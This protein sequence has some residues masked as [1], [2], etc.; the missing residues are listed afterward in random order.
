MATSKLLH[1]VLVLLQVILLVLFPILSPP[2]VHWKCDESPLALCLLITNALM[3]ASFVIGYV[4]FA[5]LVDKRLSLFGYL[6]AGLAH[7]LVVMTCVKECAAWL[8]D[9][10]HNGFRR[11]FVV[12]V[13]FVST[14]AYC[15]SV[16]SMVDESARNAKYDRDWLV[17]SLVSIMPKRIGRALTDH[18]VSDAKDDDTSGTENA[19]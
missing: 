4:Y 10:E 2:L 18:F 9:D 13:T 11:F 15:A 1:S 6:A 16:K 5:Q 8:I 7:T 12:G 19:V 3:F 14:M 17:L